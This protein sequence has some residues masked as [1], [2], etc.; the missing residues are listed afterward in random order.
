[1]RLRK[2]VGLHYIGFGHIKSNSKPNI[3]DF[4]PK[5]LEIIFQQRNLGQYSAD[6][7][8]NGLLDEFRISNYALSHGQILRIAG[9][10]TLYVPVTSPAN[11]SDFEAAKHKKVNFKDYAE[12]L[13]N[14]L[15]ENEWP[16]P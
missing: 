2:K 5:I 3:D 13:L 15:D 6:G 10:G 9:K 8:Y 11:V 1:L 12:L 14:W 7:Y 4:A 16:L